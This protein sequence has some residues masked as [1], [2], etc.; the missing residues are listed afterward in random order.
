MEKNSTSTDEP[1][2]QRKSDCAF[3]SLPTSSVLDENAS[4]FS[5]LDSF[6]ISPGHTLV[7]PKRHVGS[8]FDLSVEEIADVWQL[9]RVVRDRLR[10][11]QSPDGFNI[12]LNDGVAAGQTILHAHVHVVPRYSGDITDPR[13]GIRW[14]MPDKAKYW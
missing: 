1:R 9:V 12:G 8:L 3:C 13:G 14:L 6:P 11:Q 10:L 2:R 7:V 4:A 5:F